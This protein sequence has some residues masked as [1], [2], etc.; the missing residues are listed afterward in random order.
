[1]RRHVVPA[2]SSFAAAPSPRQSSAT[3]HGFLPMPLATASNPQYFLSSHWQPPSP[4]TIS[5]EELMQN[6]RISQAMTRSVAETREQNKVAQWK[7]IELEKQ[8][9]RQKVQEQHVDTRHAAEEVKEG[10]CGQLNA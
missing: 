5:D 2:V 3:V 6:I 10:E 7:R 4:S 8:Y 1:V 9:Y